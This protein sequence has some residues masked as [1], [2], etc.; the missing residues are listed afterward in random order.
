MAAYQGNKAAPSMNLSVSMVHAGSLTQQHKI[1]QHQR[2]NGF[3][4]QKMENACDVSI[5]ACKI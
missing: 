5:T 1:F 3:A 2:R 4:M